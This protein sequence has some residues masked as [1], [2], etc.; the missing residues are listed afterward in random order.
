[1]KSLSQFVAESLNEGII[2]VQ[3]NVNDKVEFVPTFKQQEDLGISADYKMGTITSIK[4]TTAKIFYSIL[5]DYTGTIFVDVDSC[6]VRA[7]QDVEQLEESLNES[8]KIERNSTFKALDGVTY[9]VIG[10]SGKHI[11]ASANGKK[12]E[13]NPETLISNGVKFT[14]PPKTIRKTTITKKQ[15]EKIL[16]DAVGGQDYEH[17]EIYDMAQSIIIDPEV[18]EYLTKVWR[19]EAFNPK[20]AKDTF[21]SPRWLHNRLTNDLELA[22]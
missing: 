16:D 15:Y 7:F 8:V 13:F 19:S 1:M 14:N 20:L 21:P 4:V 3:F 22:Q 18:E 11:S 10:Y 5:D 12:K 17:S 2:N 6:N 9:T